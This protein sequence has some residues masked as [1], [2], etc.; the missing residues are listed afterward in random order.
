VKPGLERGK[1]QSK[2]PMKSIVP[3]RDSAKFRHLAEIKKHWKDNDDIYEML[4]RFFKYGLKKSARA[5][6]QN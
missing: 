1:Y 6:K 5:I 4:C 3:S 2:N